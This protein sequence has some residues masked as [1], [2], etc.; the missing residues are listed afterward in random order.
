[1]VKTRTLKT[2]VATK[3]IKAT[4]QRYSRVD[5]LKGPATYRLPSGYDLL[6]RLGG[7]KKGGNYRILDAAA[8]KG[9]VGLE[10]AKRVKKSGSR[11]TTAFF[12]LTE[13]N[14]RKI[15]P[16]KAQ[17]LKVVSD[18]IAVG[19]KS[20]IFT[21]A[22]C[23]YAIKNLQY[24][25]QMIALKELF[26]VTKPSGVFIL[27]DMVSPPGLKEFQNIERVE[28]GKT[29]KENTKMHVPTEKEWK[30]MLGSAGFRV[31]KVEYT[32]SHVNTNDWVASGQ[33]K[34]ENLKSYFDFLENARGRWPKAW[35]EYKI[36]RSGDGYEITYPVILIRAVKPAK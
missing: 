10:V 9:L 35:E 12:D 26:R 8:G 34:K 16:Y 15:R 7:F 28:K 11:A 5:H 30:T 32:T 19:L 17:R 22:Y 3:R 1:M 14:L 33:M 24:P 18:L 29:S 27:Q 6:Y 20:N 36:K 4:V 25:L 13:A 31:E 21:H 2:P 23:R